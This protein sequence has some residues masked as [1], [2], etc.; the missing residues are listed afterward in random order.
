MTVI[1]RAIK[2]YGEESQIDKAIEE[3][4]ELIKALLKL[5]HCRKDYEI[6]ILKDAVAEEMADVDIMLWQLRHIYGDVKMM[7]YKDEKLK[8]LERLLDKEGV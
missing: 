2:T 3:M 4:S 1:E 8:R 5:R 6:E 7:A